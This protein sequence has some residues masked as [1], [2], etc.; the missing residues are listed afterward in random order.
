MP[1]SEEDIRGLAKFVVDEQRLR[2]EEGQV[3]QEHS[4]DPLHLPT[5]RAYDVARLTD[6]PGIAF[7]NLGAVYLALNIEFD[8]LETFAADTR[9]GEFE[10][11]TIY[12]NHP[13]IEGLQDWSFI[14]QGIPVAVA[15]LLYR[16]LDTQTVL[17][18][19]EGLYAVLQRRDISMLDPF[20]VDR[21]DLVPGEPPAR[22]VVYV[23]ST[24]KY[25]IDL[26]ARPLGPEVPTLRLG[27]YEP[28][29]DVVATGTA[30]LS[31]R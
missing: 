14:L 22:F 4:I 25:R 5:E 12:F 29:P 9:I 2:S 26:Q 7:F 18:R 13:V 3:V 28:Q 20:A 17:K 16:Y 21:R 24:N 10:K 23:P 11:H 31:V 1:V 6:Y 8:I 19:Q 15:L 27:R 30:M